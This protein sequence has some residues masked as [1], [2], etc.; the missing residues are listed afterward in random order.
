MI[1]KGF[2]V[3]DVRWIGCTVIQSKKDIPTR[4]LEYSSRLIFPLASSSNLSNK[5]RQEARK[6]QRL[7]RIDNQ[8]RSSRMLKDQLITYQNSSNPIVPDPSVL[9][10]LEGVSFPDTTN[11]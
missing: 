9:N 4:A 10:I 3:E 6:P 5:L 7:L 2:H 1:S 11:S 8:I